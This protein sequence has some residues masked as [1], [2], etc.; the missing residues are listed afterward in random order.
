V[1]LRAATRQVGGDA[2][3]AVRMLELQD[4]EPA[5]VQEIAGRWDQGLRA[6]LALAGVAG[7]IGAPLAAGKL[8]A[9]TQVLVGFLLAGVLLL[10]GGALLMTMT[11]AYGSA[12]RMPPPTSLTE[13]QRTRQDLAGRRLRFLIWGRRMATVALVLLATTIATAWGNPAADRGPVE[14]VDR[15]GVRHCGE[16]TEAPDGHVSVLAGAQ[17]RVD[18]EFTI[19]RSLR[20][21]DSCQENP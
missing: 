20:H 1:A 13:Y 6:L 18:V 17:G 10:A 16:L 5:M 14:V 9:A 4:L 8:A 15:N 2:V 19:V 3:M 7:L 21:V 11:A 12:R